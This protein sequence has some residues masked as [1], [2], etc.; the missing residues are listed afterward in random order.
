MN[1]SRCCV[2]KNCRQFV[3]LVLFSQT[4][5]LLE[6]WLRRWWKRTLPPTGDDR[7]GAIVQACCSPDSSACLLL[8]VAHSNSIVLPKSGLNFREIIFCS[9]V[10]ELPEQMVLHVAEWSVN[11][12]R[13]WNIWLLHYRPE[14]LHSAPSTCTSH[15]PKHTREDDYRR[16][17]C[18]PSVYVRKVEL[19]PL[20]IHL[21][22]LIVFF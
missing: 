17:I 5:S 14:L 20:N 7:I 2:K 1:S 22:A 16:Q 10:G 9:Q 19:R 12:Q 13:E 8:S 15:F 18:K 4:D 6:V 21:K 11:C 3:L